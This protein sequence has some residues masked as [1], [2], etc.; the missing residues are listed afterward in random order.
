MNYRVE[1]VLRDRFPSMT[2]EQL[3]RMQYD[4]SGCYHDAFGDEKVWM[5]PRLIYRLLQDL[6]DEYEDEV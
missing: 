1:Q 2:N 6:A 3:D 4:N 5:S